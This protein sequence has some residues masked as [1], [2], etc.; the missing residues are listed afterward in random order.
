MHVV[1]EAIIRTCIAYIVLLGVSLWVGK[2]VNSHTNYYNFALSITIGSF[3]AN[4]GF[5]TNL[6]FAPMISSFLALILIYFF[7]SLISANSRPFRKWLSGQPTV[8]ID[9][10]KILDANMKKIRYTLDDLNQQ[11]R[12]QGIFDLF[13]VEYALL[14]VSGKLSVLKKTQYQNVSKKDVN[15]AA[16][17]NENVMLPKELIMDGKLIEKNFN[18]NFSKNWL[19]QELKL[20][21]LEIKAVQY[22]VI[23]SNG[24]LF[25]DLF[26]D[27]LKSPL[28]TE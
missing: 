19:D 2:Q 8:I 27:H 23:S 1:F 5:D 28:D 17:L 6:H 4:M 18:H 16:N 24:S 25:I 22:A 12:E 3:I 20:R 7:L 11:L 14:E 26:D 10:G 15:P 13:E 9:N 21:S